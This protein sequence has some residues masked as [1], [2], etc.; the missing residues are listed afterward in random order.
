MIIAYMQSPRACGQGTLSH[1]LSFPFHQ[2]LAFVASP[3]FSPI[4]YSGSTIPI[5]SI[6][7]CSVVHARAWL[8]TLRK[9][10]LGVFQQFYG[11]QSNGRCSGMESASTE[12]MIDQLTNMYGCARFQLF[13]S[14]YY[15]KLWR[16][17]LLCRLNN[18]ARREMTLSISHQLTINL[19][20]SSSVLLADSIVPQFHACIHACSIVN[21]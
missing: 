17:K 6:E 2:T 8:V 21:Q 11:K 19:Q 18:F 4:T 3:L 5:P 14:N 20:R 15:I 9:L 1:P 10:F 12:L 16:R 13:R 7:R